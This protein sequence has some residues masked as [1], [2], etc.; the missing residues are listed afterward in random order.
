VANVM[1]LMLPS[2]HPSPQPKQHLDRLSRFVGFT[3]VTDR[4]TERERERG[5]VVEEGE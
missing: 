3:S 1:E 2:V 4:Q 5:R